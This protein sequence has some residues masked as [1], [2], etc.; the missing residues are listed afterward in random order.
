MLRNLSKRLIH[1]GQAIP[2]SSVTLVVGSDKGKYNIEPNVDTKTYFTN[3]KVVLVGFPGAFTPTCTATHI[4]EY[5]KLVEQ[6][7]QKGAHVVALTV[8]DPFVCKEFGEELGGG[9][10]FLADGAGKFTMSLDAGV[11]LSD[12]ALGYRT[13]RFSAFVEDGTITQLNDE[14][15]PGMTD[16]SRAETMLKSI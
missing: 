16:L 4:P 9:I 10:T 8:N 1:I 15:G 2:E 14:G 13:R 5:I 12:K 3:K 7:K 11:D 6:F